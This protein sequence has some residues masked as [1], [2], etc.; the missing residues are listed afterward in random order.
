MIT[1]AIKVLYE[2]SDRGPKIYAR[3]LPNIYTQ[4]EAIWPQYST[5]KKYT[6]TKTRKAVFRILKERHPTVK[7]SSS[8][9]Y[10]IIPNNISP[11]KLGNPAKPEPPNPSQKSTKPGSVSSQLRFNLNNNIIYVP[12]VP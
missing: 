6:L 1:D 5:R 4:V 11:C 10:K 9:F 12:F 3:P 2:F 8:T 7:M